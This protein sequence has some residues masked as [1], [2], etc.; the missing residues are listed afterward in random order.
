MN[1]GLIERRR[2]MGDL[3]WVWRSSDLSTGTSIKTSESPVNPS[4]FYSSE[5]WVINVN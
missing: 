1:H 2:I 4:V 3:G 5:S